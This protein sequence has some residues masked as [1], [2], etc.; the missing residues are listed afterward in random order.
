MNKIEYEFYLSKIFQEL[1]H[2][3]ENTSKFNSKDDDKFYIFL[4]VTTNKYEELFGSG[5]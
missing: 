1:L 3:K 2:L 5:V 4:R